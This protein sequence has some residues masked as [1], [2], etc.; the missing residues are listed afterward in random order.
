MKTKLLL[1]SLLLFLSCTSK[2]NSETFIEKAEGRYFFNA[3]EVIEVYFK[4][5]ELFLKWRNSDLKPLKLNDSSFYARE[6]NEKLIFNLAESKISLA[7]KRE[8]KKEKIVF[9]KIKKGEK[10]PSEYLN[11]NNFEMALKGFL[12][13]KNKDSLNPLIQRRTINRKGYDFLRNNEIDKAITTFKINVELYPNHSNPYDSLGDAFAKKQDTVE[14]L[15]QYKKALSINPENR[16]SK[17][18]IKR[19]T[20]KDE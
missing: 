15:K 11:E 3:D 7:E 1:L 17:R 18:N 5:S 2:K 9:T 12:A 20:K 14:A 6:L 19:L 16:S 10:T 13:I 8:H 4:N